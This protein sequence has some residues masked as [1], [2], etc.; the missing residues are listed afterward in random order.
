LW[1]AAA[2]GKEAEV[3]EILL[4]TPAL[5]VNWRNYQRLDQSTLHKACFN[6]NDSTSLLL[7]HPDINVNVEDTHGATPFHW[8][9]GY[10]KISIFRL[11]L[12]D[13][14]VNVLKP[15]KLYGGRAPLWKAASNGHLGVIKWW[16]ASGKE[17]DLGK[18]GNFS[19]DT[20]IMAR[21]KKALEVVSL[22]ERFQENPEDTRH[23]IR[24]EL[25]WYDEA[26]AEIFGLVVF[27]CD[28]LLEIKGNVED[29]EDSVKI[30]EFFRITSQLPMERQMVLCHRVVGSMKNNIAGEVR[31]AAFK[32]TPQ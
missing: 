26:A 24:R 9:C 18:P 17:M 22:L 4:A 16:I 11:L 3:K 10:G 2:G 29:E 23:E 12:A 32:A 14:R 13:S 27:L 1:Y 31:E 6:G 19:T 15:D 8:A 28:G 7:A 20:I 25:G 30:M 5:D 21:L